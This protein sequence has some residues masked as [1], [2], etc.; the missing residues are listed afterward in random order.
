MIARRRQE[1]SWTSSKA[2]SEEKKNN[3]LPVLT[4]PIIPV[5]A[6]SPLTQ[7]E[8]VNYSS[9][10]SHGEPTALTRFQTLSWKTAPTPLLQH[11][12]TSSKDLLTPASYPQTGIELTFQLFSR[13]EISIYQKTTAPISLMS[14]LCYLLEHIIYHHLMTH[15]KKHN[16]LT[17]LNHGF[18]AGFSCETQ[19]VTTMF[20]LFSSFDPGTQVGMAIL[21]LSKA[22]DTV[23]HSKLLHKLSHY[24]IA[25]TTLRWLEDFLTRPTIRVVLNGKLSRE[26]PVDSGVPQGTVLSPLLFLCRIN[27]LLASSNPNSVCWWLPTVVRNYSI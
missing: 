13:K 2:S 24:G 3:F 17:H 15:L 8:Y 1:F 25:G 5:Q 18:R 11:S 19:L 6:T 7:L 23:P 26:V 21:D 16:V 4:L 22:F 27:V 10:S 12:V 14:I 9:P 20:D